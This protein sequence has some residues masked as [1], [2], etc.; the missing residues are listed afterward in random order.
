MTKTTPEQAPQSSNLHTML[1]SGLCAKTDLKSINPS[2]LLNLP[3]GSSLAPPRATR[4]RY[5]TTP[6]ASFWRR[7]PL[8]GIFS[9]AAMQTFIRILRLAC[10]ASFKNGVW[11]LNVDKQA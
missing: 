1:R 11:K 7:I 9:N 4:A 6:L 3:S 8:L 10:Y 5:S 2:V